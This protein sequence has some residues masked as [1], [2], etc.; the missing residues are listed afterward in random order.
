MP[1]G[2]TPCRNLLPHICDP[3]SSGLLSHL[4]WQEGVK[5]MALDPMQLPSKALQA[6][7][8][9]ILLHSDHHFSLSQHVW[10]H[11]YTSTNAQVVSHS[12]SSL[13][14]AHIS[15]RAVSTILSIQKAI[16][17]QSAPEVLILADLHK[18]SPYSC[19][20]IIA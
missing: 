1:R 15:L 3:V 12:P 19:Y 10:S 4:P 8:L 13:C 7:T 20:K 2:D 16:C 14:L 17:S 5:P 9:I 11:L 18:L 6:Q